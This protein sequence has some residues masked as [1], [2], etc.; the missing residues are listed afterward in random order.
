[1]DFVDQAL[2]RRLESA[3]E[4]PQVR[5]AEMYQRVHP[6]IGAAFEPVCGGHMIFAGVGSPIGRVTGAGFK[7]PVSAAEIDRIED[8]YRAHGAPSQI[9]VC[10]L[11]HGS[12]MELV[13]QRNYTLAEL[14]NVLYRR[15]DPNETFPATAG[16]RPGRADE[17]A[18]FSAIMERC[19]FPDG[20]SP[21]DIGVL[22]GM[23]LQM[24]GALTFV[25]E[26]D[27][28]GAACAAGLMILEHRIIA[29]S[30]AGTL[31]EYRRRGLQTA[32]LQARMAAA[33]KAG[34][35]YAVI[36]T[37]GGS[38]SQHNAERLGFRVAYSKATML[39]N[40]S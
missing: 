39:K 25:A 4:V 31:T 26:V 3:E 17:A 24:N 2:A 1:M 28:K 21:H 32:M 18:E 40:L 12:L 8:F 23:L 20:N 33:A 36:V 5:Y 29:L 10:P 9:D 27:G 38:T 11:T 35:E 19:F 7:G 16:I 6:Q 30:G 37:N 34:C 14:N 15:L 13:K 22:F